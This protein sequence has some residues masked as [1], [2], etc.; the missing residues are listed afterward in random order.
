MREIDALFCASDFYHRTAVEVYR[1]GAQLFLTDNDTDNID[2]LGGG[3]YTY[4]VC[5]EGAT[6]CSN[7]AV[8][9]F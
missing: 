7:E 3:S 2:N 5:E 4:R 8:V 6:T 9:S 1:D